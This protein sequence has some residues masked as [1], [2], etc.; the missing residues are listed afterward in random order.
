MVALFQISAIN[1]SPEDFPGSKPNKSV[2][3]KTSTNP[4]KTKELWFGHGSIEQSSNAGGCTAILGSLGG[5]WFQT[6][7]K[8]S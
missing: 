4:P 8:S 3:R 1:L 5:L 6:G 7:F 2:N